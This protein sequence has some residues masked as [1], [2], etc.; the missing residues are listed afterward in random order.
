[1][2]TASIRTY[3]E[4]VHTLVN[5]SSYTGAFLPGYRTESGEDPIASALPGI[6]LEAIDHCVGNMDWDGMEAACE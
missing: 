2:R 4:T 5:R 1:M 6:D 3:G